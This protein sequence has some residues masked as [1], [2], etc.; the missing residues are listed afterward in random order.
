MDHIGA[1]TYAVKHLGLSCPCF[2][3]TPVHDMGKALLEDIVQSLQE[4]V[5]FDIFTMAD[6]ELALNKM[7]LLRYSQPFSLYGTCPFSLI[8]GSHL[9]GNCIRKGT[10]DSH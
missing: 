5:A 8:R 7:T 10:G 1:Y 9:K 6:V 4:E 3:T 2:A